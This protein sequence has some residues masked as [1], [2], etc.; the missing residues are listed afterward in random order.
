Q[1]KT[2]EAAKARQ[3]IQQK[4]EELNNA[5]ATSVD[6]RGKVDECAKN[7]KSCAA[8]EQQLCDALEKAM[9]ALGD[10]DLQGERTISLQ[11]Q[12]RQ[13]GFE[14]NRSDLLPAARENLSKLAGILSWM[15]AMGS[16]E[17]IEV[18]GHTD[19]T[20]IDNYK[21]SLERNVPLSNDRA[22]RVKEYL[23]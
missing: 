4:Q 19:A 22:N 15:L 18:G 5:L 11:L 9:K 8:R 6:L 1:I 21:K 10:Y 17:H 7:K 23:E 12:E 13:I 2:E 20:P 16:I 14:K 3:E